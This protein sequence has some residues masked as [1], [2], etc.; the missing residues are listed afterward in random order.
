[1]QLT[2]A[3]ERAGRPVLDPWDRTVGLVPADQAPALGRKP[4]LTAEAVAGRKPLG[5]RPKTFEQ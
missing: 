2:G 5:S 1:M 4:L 3:A